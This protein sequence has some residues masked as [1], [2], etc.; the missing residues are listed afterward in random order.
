MVKLHYE[1]PIAKPCTVSQFSTVVA[2]RSVRG[3]A[4]PGRFEISMFNAFLEAGQ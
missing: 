1:D 2:S 3:A 4:D